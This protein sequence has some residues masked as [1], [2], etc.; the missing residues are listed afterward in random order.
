[1]GSGAV[2]APRHTR[3]YGTDVPQRSG[4]Q[5]AKPAPK[6]RGRRLS[7]RLS[8]DDW[9]AAALELLARD[10][11]DAVKLNRLCEELG[12][13]KGSFYWHF[14]DITDLKVA[15]ATRWCALTEQALDS[16]T[17]LAELSPTDLL[18][19]MTERLIDDRTWSVER[20][21]RDWARTDEQ[22]AA[23]ITASDRHV[24]EVVQRA[25]LDLGF[26]AEQARVRAG[27]LVYAGIGFA[28]GQQSL[29]KPTMA[30]VDQLLALLTHQDVRASGTG[31]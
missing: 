18:R 22:V 4:Q 15:V 11:V 21:V 6:P 14:T 20:A 24:F 8:L 19:R 1:V 2:G 29:P 25:L 12:V 13:T 26:T 9:T 30:D 16:L 23:A 7:E 27:T 17:G 31:P 28:H 3:R 10:G 5:A